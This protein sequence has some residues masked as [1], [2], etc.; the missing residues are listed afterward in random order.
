[1][2]SWEA[3]GRTGERVSAADVMQAAL[4]IYRDLGER[5]AEADA[6]VEP[7]QGSQ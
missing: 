1:L 4:R 3:R 7:R 2:S 5:P 6:L